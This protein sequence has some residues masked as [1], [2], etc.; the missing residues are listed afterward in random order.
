MWMLFVKF[1]MFFIK[2]KTAP[3][4]WGAV[5][6]LLLGG[7]GFWSWTTIQDQKRDMIEQTLNHENEG[8][9]NVNEQLALDQESI[10]SRM[11]MLAGSLENLNSSY[12]RSIT[13]RDQAVDDL[14][15]DVPSGE[16]PDTM[17]MRRRA[18]E[19]MNALF[20]DLEVTSG[21]KAEDE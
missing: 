13:R 1:G 6:I 12:A 3:L 11:E 14:T 21:K 15:V 8:L 4:A 16:A 7:Y 5:A 10:M 2:P 19:G 18:N 20:D 9:R 17:E